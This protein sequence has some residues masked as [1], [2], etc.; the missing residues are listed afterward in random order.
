MLTP[1]EIVITACTEAAEDFAELR[2]APPDCDPTTANVGIFTQEPR[3]MLGAVTRYALMHSDNPTQML[4]DVA[5]A[6]VF[7]MRVD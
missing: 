3:F 2:L 4:A 7:R 6:L 5:R 1:D